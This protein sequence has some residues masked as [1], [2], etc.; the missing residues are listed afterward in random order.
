MN[1]IQT[2][3]ISLLSLGDL[4]ANRGMLVYLCVYVWMIDC[5][6]RRGRYVGASGYTVSSVTPWDKQ[7]G[8]LR[9]MSLCGKEFRLEGKKRHR[10]Y[11][12]LANAICC[13]LRV[14]SRRPFQSVRGCNEK[15]DRHRKLV[16]TR[17]KL[18]TQQKKPSNSEVIDRSRKTNSGRTLICQ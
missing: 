1:Q 11:F 7:R 14:H 17:M 6:W 13:L 3:W 2:V 4:A 18:F 12:W 15:D 10:C 16:L 8:G 5:E 9:Q